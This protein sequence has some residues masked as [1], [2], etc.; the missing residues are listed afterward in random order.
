M[1]LSFKPKAHLKRCV[2]FDPGQIKNSPTSSCERSS[3][4]AVNVQPCLKKD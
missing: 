2:F 4:S 1:E 3:H